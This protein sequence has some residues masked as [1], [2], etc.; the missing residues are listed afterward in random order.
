MGYSKWINNTEKSM[1]MIIENILDYKEWLCEEQD[2]V[3]KIALSYNVEKVF[4]ESQEVKVNDKDLSFNLIKYEYERFT[5]G[6][7]HKPLKSE[8]INCMSGS[9]I[10][11]SEEGITKFIVDKSTMAESI[12]KKINNYDGNEVRK[13]SYNLEEDFLKWIFYKGR[14]ASNAPLGGTEEIF[15]EGIAR[16]KSET[17]DHLAIMESIGSSS[18]ILSSP[19]MYAFLS[20]NSS[21]LQL[22]AKVR[23]V[24]KISAD[25]TEIFDLFLN[26]SRNEC[27]SV[28]FDTYCGVYMRDPEEIRNAKILL[29]TMIE[30]LPKLLE[31]YNDEKTR[32]AWPEKEKEHFLNGAIRGEML[33]KLKKEE[34]EYDLSR[35]DPDR[36]EILRNAIS[37]IDC[38]KDSEEKENAE[39]DIQYITKAILNEN[40]KRALYLSRALANDLKLDIFNELRGFEELRKMLTKAYEESRKK[41][42]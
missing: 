15:L 8:R 6:S 31:V 42:V 33:R 38:L 17:K 23:W 12:L 13:D 35:L 22:Q 24:K 3:E 10:I 28:E 39:E 37:D 40:F 19:N 34:L 9:I 16:F 14:E 5:P 21:I 11:Y 4:E 2:P 7:R 29:V 25:Q 30:V 1:D 18:K 32:G 20:G 36:Q 26:R 41:I 27:V